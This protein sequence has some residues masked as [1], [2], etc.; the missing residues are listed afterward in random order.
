MGAERCLGFFCRKERRSNGDLS[1]GIGPEDLHSKRAY[2][3]LAFVFSFDYYRAMS[4]VTLEVVIENGRVI[5]RGSEVL[6]EKGAGFLTIL[7]EVKSVRER[8]SITE[9][10]EKWA[11]KF[12]SPELPSGD[13]R[14]DDLLEKHVK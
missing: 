8:G 4:L 14:L 12:S 3:P 2:D 9:F 1:K 10:I 13:A 6:P 5:P 11:G 7:P